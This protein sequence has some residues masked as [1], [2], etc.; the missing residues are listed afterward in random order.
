[1]QSAWDDLSDDKKLEFVH[2]IARGATTMSKLLVD[3]ETVD[4]IDAGQSSEAA[5]LD[6]GA[7]I[8]QIVSDVVAHGPR[9]AMTNV[10][11]GLPLAMADEA[12]QRRVI[13]NL[14]ENAFKFSPENVPVEVD[15]DA[16]DGFVRVTVR[17]RGPGIGDEDKAKLFQRFS[18]LRSPDGKK[19]AGSGLGLYICKALVE[20][21]GGRIWVES[22]VGEGSA[23]RYTVPVSAEPAA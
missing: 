12:S 10:A 13:S 20:A 14:L 6:L 2:A 19:I 4:A 11:G 21:Q 7:M 18:R 16:I 5:P 22:E 3:M 17:D 9:D 8:R 23:F 15:V 1:M